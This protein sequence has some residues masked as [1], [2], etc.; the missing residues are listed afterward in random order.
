MAP[1]I[2]ASPGEVKSTAPLPSPTL[3]HSSPPLVERADDA[4]TTRYHSL[5]APWVFP[6]EC[7]LTYKMTSM[8]SDIADGYGKVEETF[9]WHDMWMNS[10]WSSCQPR[11]AESGYLS[12]QF[13]T[14]KAASVFRGAVCP[15]GWMAFDVGLASQTR[16]KDRKALPA[17]TWSTA[18]CCRM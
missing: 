12:T 4:S 13:G 10:H 6:S 11:G 3:H 8:S 5:Q 2:T 17:E 16:T 15:K 1:P 7:S 9:L 14:A 18:H